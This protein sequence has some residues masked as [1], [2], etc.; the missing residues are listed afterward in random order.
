MTRP[1]FANPRGATQIPR[2]QRIRK[3]VPENL[4]LI[5][6]I[7]CD[8]IIIYAVTNYNEVATSI[9]VDLLINVLSQ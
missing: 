4:Y 6:F 1:I 9:Y 5:L 3:L 8:G 2:V 7:V